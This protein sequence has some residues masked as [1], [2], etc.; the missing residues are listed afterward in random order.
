MRVCPLGLKR[1]LKKETAN[2]K[3]KIR[4]MNTLYYGDNLTVLHE[5]IAD[6]SVD[7]IYLDPPFNSKAN[8]NVLYKEPSGEPSE[9]QITAFEDTWHW[10]GDTEREAHLNLY[11]RQGGVYSY[12]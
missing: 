3:D 4:L 7:L 10:T 11:L 6:E 9:A 12:Q 2:Q 5:H 1:P 8:Y